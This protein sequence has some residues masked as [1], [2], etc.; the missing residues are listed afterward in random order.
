MYLYLIYITLYNIYIIY[1]RVKCIYVLICKLTSALYMI[2]DDIPW[3][4]KMEE[5]FRRGFY[6]NMTGM[7][8]F[9]S[10]TLLNGGVMS[11]QLGQNH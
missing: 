4:A 5:Q 1:I 11:L 3:R 10:Y 7:T 2:N 9:L 8:S 6:E